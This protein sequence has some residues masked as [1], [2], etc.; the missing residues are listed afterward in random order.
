MTC[1]GRCNRYLECMPL[2][3][4]DRDGGRTLDLTPE[5]RGLYRLSHVKKKKK[6]KAVHRYQE[7]WTPI[8][9]PLI[10][11]YEELTYNI[12]VQSSMVKGG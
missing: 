2:L 9:A 10:L 4:S 12:R 11:Q 5:S 6:K 7:S 3:T 8:N 1:F